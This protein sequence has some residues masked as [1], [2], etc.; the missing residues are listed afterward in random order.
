MIHNI[1]TLKNGSTIIIREANFN[2][3]MGIN[4]LAANIYATTDQ[5]LTSAKEFDPLSNLDSQIKRIQHY[6][7]AKGKCFL[8]AEHN[9]KLIGMID[10]SNGHRLKNQ[11]TGEL[12]MG[13]LEEFRNFG[14]GRFLMSDMIQWAKENPIINKLKLAVFASNS[15]A[16]SLYKNLGFVEEGRKIDEIKQLNGTLIDVIEMY[17]KV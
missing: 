2:D 4:E 8:L 10:F 15:A 3:A 6:N 5:T 17:L 13:V 16:V 1:H 9:N 11:H 7:E 14:V 12:G